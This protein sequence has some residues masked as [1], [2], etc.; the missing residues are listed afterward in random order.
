VKSPGTIRTV[1]AAGA[2]TSGFVLPTDNAANR[3]SS[4]GSQPSAVT[5]ALKI[6]PTGTDF[7]ACN[8]AKCEQAFYTI[9]DL[10]KRWHCSRASVYNILRGQMVIDFAPQPGRKGHKLVSAD[11][12]RQIENRR[13]RRLT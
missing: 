7:A 8:T 10:A 13:A 12:V 4:A 1:Q 2:V 11:V 6:E 9:P 5:A 3:G